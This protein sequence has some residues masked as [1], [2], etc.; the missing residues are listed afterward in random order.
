MHSPGTDRYKTFALL[1]MAAYRDSGNMGATLNWHG[2]SPSFGYLVGGVT[3]RTI[4]VKASEFNITDVEN[5][6]TRAYSQE[7]LA[8]PGN[9][10]GVWNDGLEVHI[11]VSVNVGTMEHALAQAKLLNQ[12]AVWDIAAGVEIAVMA[13]E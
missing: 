2:Q 5:F 13:D 3:Y 10:V 4:R 12:V 1:V 6:I 8:Q 9:Y 7:C 11:D